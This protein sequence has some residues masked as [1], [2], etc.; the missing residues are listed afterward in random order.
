MGA[1]NWSLLCVTMERRP[2]GGSTLVTCV[3]VCVC[4]NGEA[5]ILGAEHWSLLCVTIER[6]PFG[7]STLVTC[8]CDNGEASVCFQRDRASLY[9]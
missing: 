8:V 5:P 1:V 6:R 2:F 7:G 9:R 4:D 3:C